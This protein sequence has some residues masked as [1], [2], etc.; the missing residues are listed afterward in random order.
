MVMIIS[1]HLVKFICEKN[2]KY[3]RVAPLGMSQFHFI[4]PIENLKKLI[5]IQI[6][7]FT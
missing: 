1:I 3:S 4:G 6:N 7:I 2:K 5:F